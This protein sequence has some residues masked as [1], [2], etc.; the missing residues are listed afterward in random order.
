[1]AQRVRTYQPVG[2]GVFYLHRVITAGCS[3]Y[4]MVVDEV[5]EYPIDED[6]E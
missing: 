4:S 6:T 2:A 1:M 5:A 3:P